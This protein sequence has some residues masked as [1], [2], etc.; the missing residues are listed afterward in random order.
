[1][2]FRG[3]PQKSETTFRRQ[4][5]KLVHQYRSR[6]FRRTSQHDELF[7]QKRE[8]E[9]LGAIFEISRFLFG[10]FR[11]A[12]RKFEITFVNQLLIL[13]PRHALRF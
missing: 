4:N 13:F 1:M 5:R 12:S 9:V 10:M 6:P 2:I 8:I 3:A 11:G 7:D